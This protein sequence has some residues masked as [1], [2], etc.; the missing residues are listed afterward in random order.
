MQAGRSEAGA[1]NEGNQEGPALDGDDV[2]LLIDIESHFFR[3]YD[4]LG[5]TKAFRLFEEF[6]E[7]ALSMKSAEKRKH[8]LKHK[9]F[10]MKTADGRSE[11]SGTHDGHKFEDRKLNILSKLPF[12]CLL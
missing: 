7:V 11:P 3:Y 1:T 4:F 8:L 6:R 9:L 10:L 2:L 5:K 12:L